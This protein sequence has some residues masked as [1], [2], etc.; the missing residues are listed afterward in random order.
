MNRVI[1]Q[2]HYSL[3]TYSKTAE[4]IIVTYATLEQE[5]QM[6][7]YFVDHLENVKIAGKKSNKLFQYSYTTQTGDRVYVHNNNDLEKLL[8]LRIIK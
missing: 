6:S 8:W 7:E 1:T 5:L 4:E 2:I 3:L